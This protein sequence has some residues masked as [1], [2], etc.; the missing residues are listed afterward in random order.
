MKLLLCVALATAACTAGD[1]TLDSRA[2][3]AVVD[4]NPGDA[5]GGDGYGGDSDGGG[6]PACFDAQGAPVPCDSNLAA[7]CYAEDGTAVACP[8]PAPGDLDGD[9]QPDATDPDED[10]DEIADPS[11]SDANDNGIIDT[12]DPALDSDG[13]GITNDADGDDDGDGIPDGSD[14][15]PTDNDS[16]GDGIPN[17]FDDDD[18]NDGIPDYADADPEDT[19]SDGDGIDNEDDP[20]DDNDDIPDWADDEPEEPSDEDDDGIADGEDNDDDGDG[21][22]DPDDPYPD[23]PSDEC[24]ADDDDED[25]GCADAEQKLPDPY[26]RKPLEKKLVAAPGKGSYT[27]DPAAITAGTQLASFD[28]WN[29]RYIGARRS[30]FNDVSIYSGV[31]ISEMMQIS[32]RVFNPAG[33]QLQVEIGREKARLTTSDGCGWQ[34]L[35]ATMLTHALSFPSTPGYQ[36]GNTVKLTVERVNAAPTDTVKAA[37]VELVFKA[38]A[39]IFLVHGI[40]SSNGEAWPRWREDLARLGYITNEDIDLPCGGS[41]LRYI[42]STWPDGSPHVGYN[43]NIDNNA[44][45]IRDQLPGLLRQYGTTDAHFI[46]HSKGGLDT[47]A[48]FRQFY[49]Q[50]KGMAPGQVD[51]VSWTTIDSPHKGS[52]LAPLNSGMFLLWDLLRAQTAP[53]NVIKWAPTPVTTTGVPFTPPAVITN[54]TSSRLAAHFTEAEGP[55]NAIVFSGPRMQDLTPREP[56]LY[57][58]SPMSPAVVAHQTLR[59]DFPF[60]AV[61]FDVDS[62]RDG[63]VSPREAGPF[64]LGD[65]FP[66]YFASTWFGNWLMNSGTNIYQFLRSVRDLRIGS[67]WWW[68]DVMWDPPSPFL[69]RNGYFSFVWWLQS[70]AQPNDLMVT[71]DSA[72]HPAARECPYYEGGDVFECQT[73]GVVGSAGWLNI[74]DPTGAQGQV[75]RAASR[76]SASHT[77][78]RQTRCALYDTLN[79]LRRD[80]PLD[81]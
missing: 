36:S 42:A 56:G 66:T 73:R 9:G 45:K 26:D 1:D 11:D 8:G 13:D 22:A 40:D 15:E 61:G 32:V 21:C 31:T 53:W 71:K 62:N 17:M 74:P 16:D 12:Q 39:P 33:L 46:V 52:A 75:Y 55:F 68:T 3:A 41:C 25:D 59:V 23:Y 69:Q 48:Y 44:A 57:D 79:R 72:C 76:R 7:Y 29:D 10:G 64:W 81:E 63:Q 78:A 43:D 38:H 51:V 28:V 47:G 49:P 58:L 80:Y 60:Y 70:T 5:F 6:S 35:T 20:D 4:A 30:R 18:D 24:D 2:R 19:D 14:V 37:W 54:L 77:G 65:K 34:T 50:Q 67:L 27:G